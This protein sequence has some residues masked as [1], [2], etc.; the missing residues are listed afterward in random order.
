MIASRPSPAFL[1]RYASGSGSASPV[2]SMMMRCGRVV[3]TISCREIEAILVDR[4]A[5]AAARELDHGLDGRQSRDHA[6]VDSDLA[7]LVHD[8]RHGLAT[9]PVVEHVAQQGGLS[10]P[11]ESRQDVDGYGV[12]GEG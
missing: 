12:H 2:D 3:S 10:A 5:D 11:E 9:Q 6:T 4:A 8:D 7:D 1:T